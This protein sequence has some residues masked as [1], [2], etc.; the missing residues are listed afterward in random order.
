MKLDPLSKSS[1]KR[2]LTCPWKA[3]AVKNLGFEESYGP[4]AA[5]GVEFH[6]L[7]AKVLQKE[8]TL[9]QALP[10]ARDDEM[11]AMLDRTLILLPNFRGKAEEHVLVDKN[12]KRTDKEEKAIVH[13]YLDVMIQEDDETA[14]VIDWKTGRWEQ[15][16]VFERHL[17]AGMLA[18]AIFP[19]VRAIRF[20]LRFTRSGNILE[21]IYT[22]EDK[23]NLHILAPDGSES[24]MYDVKGPMNAWI[25]G[26]R[27]AIRQT[28]AEPRPGEWCVKNYGKKCDFNGNICPLSQ[29][30][31]KALEAFVMQ[32]DPIQA[33]MAARNGVI[34]QSTAG[35]VYQAIGQMESVLE[36]VKDAVKNWSKENGNFKVGDSEYGWFNRKVYSVDEAFALETLFEAGLSYAEIAKVVNLSKTSLGRLSKRNYPELIEALQFAIDRKDGPPTFGAIKELPPDNGE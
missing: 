5:W 2:F 27:N 33:L 6:E 36:N 12:G 29:N 13:G 28:K 17:Y 32:K 30:A 34:T 19:K 8:L 10:K 31:D 14:L 15:D 25:A 18:R 24:T 21:S 3:H 9:E 35:L 11:A 20:Q 7:I 22:W 16:D 26:I 4:A 1:Y 23:N